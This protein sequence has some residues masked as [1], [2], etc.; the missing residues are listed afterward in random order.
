[1]KDFVP[2][3]DNEESDWG[4]MLLASPPEESALATN[5]MKLREIL[6]FETTVMALRL[7]LMVRKS[8]L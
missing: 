1:M 7:P 4:I 8:V 6:K 3:S 2:S 5:V